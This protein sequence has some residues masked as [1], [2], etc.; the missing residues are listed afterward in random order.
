MSRFN[1]L[2]DTC[3]CFSGYT[4]QNGQCLVEIKQYPVVPQYDTQKYAIPI[5][6]QMPIATPTKAYVRSTRGPTPILTSTI[7]PTKTQAK[8]KK[9]I[10]N[11]IKATP[12]LA[13]KKSW[14]QWLFGF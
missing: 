2:N 10:K 12:T 8:I 5:E 4:I 7:K 3:E 9:T 6:T 1:S 13:P 14:W 11:V